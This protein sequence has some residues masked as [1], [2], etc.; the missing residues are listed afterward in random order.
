MERLGLLLY[1]VSISTSAP[2]HTRENVPHKLSMV[3]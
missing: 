1:D 2:K 3:E